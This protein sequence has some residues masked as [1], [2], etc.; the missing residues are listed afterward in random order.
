MN[1]INRRINCVVQK[2][3]QEKQFEPLQIIMG[4]EGDV[5]DNINLNE[6]FIEVEKFLED[7]VFAVIYDKMET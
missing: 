1:L 6:E 5:P 3:I 4:L 7:K 2:T